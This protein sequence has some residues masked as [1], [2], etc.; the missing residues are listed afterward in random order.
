MSA[1]INPRNP[2][3]KDN[4]LLEYDYDSD[5]DWEEEEPGEDLNAMSDEEE[6]EEEENSDVCKAFSVL[7]Y[8]PKL[9]DDGWLV[10]DGYVSE[11]EGMSASDADD[12][13]LPKQAPVASQQTNEAAGEDS[14]AERN[15]SGKSHKAKEKLDN[16]K[17]SKGKK[18]QE[19]KGKGLLLS[20]VGPIFC[21]SESG[22][23]GD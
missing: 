11:D 6:E 14:H 3:K 7:S 16:T 13:D 8:Q 18:L 19:P 12:E 17:K 5:A 21:I 23:P 2:F 15:G 4:T 22:R 9:Q 10:P 1:I 20:A